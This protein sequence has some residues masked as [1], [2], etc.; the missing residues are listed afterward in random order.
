MEPN[1]NLPKLDNSAG[2]KDLVAA[3][4]KIVDYITANH[5]RSGPGIVVTP[6]DNGKQIEIGKLTGTVT[7]NGGSPPTFTITFTAN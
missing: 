5:I 3:Y 2:I 1:V 4:S 7:C 6:S